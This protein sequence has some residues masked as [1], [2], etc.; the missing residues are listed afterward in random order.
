[1]SY[2]IDIVMRQGFSID[3]LTD[4]LRSNPRY[5]FTCNPIA[6]KRKT[7]RHAAKKITYEWRHKKY[8]GSIKVRK[9]HGIFWAEVKRGVW[10]SFLKYLKSRCRTEGNSLKNKTGVPAVFVLGT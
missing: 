1:M 7:S 2:T 8:G 5:I 9:S 10:E 4:L 6:R 3:H